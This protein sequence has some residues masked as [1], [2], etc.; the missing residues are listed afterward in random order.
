MTVHSPVGFGNA[1]PFIVNKN[2]LPQTAIGPQTET[3]DA[4]H[5]IALTLEGQLYN[6]RITTFG[7]I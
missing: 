1:V 4:V 2:S 7:S 5:I 6:F 3:H